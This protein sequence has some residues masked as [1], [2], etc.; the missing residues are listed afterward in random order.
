MIN[1]ASDIQNQQSPS[2]EPPYAAEEA[3]PS[4]PRRRPWHLYSFAAVAVVWA[5]HERTRRHHHATRRCQR[6]AT[7][8]HGNAAGGHRIRQRQ[9]N[10]RSRIQG[11][12]R[13]RTAHW[14]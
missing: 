8:P 9:P 10:A 13:T 3:R 14:S 6:R 7:G 2:Q 5:V 4:G 1:R 12:R 11:M